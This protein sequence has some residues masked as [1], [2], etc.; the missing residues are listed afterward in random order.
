MIFLN[1]LEL[2]LCFALVFIK[3]LDACWSPY[4]F[5][6]Y[7]CSETRGYHTS[8]AVRKGFRKQ[9]MGRILSASTILTVEFN[10]TIL[11]C[12]MWSPLASESTMNSWWLTVEVVSALAEPVEPSAQW[13]WSW[14]KKLIQLQGGWTR[15]CVLKYRKSF[16]S[17]RTR[18]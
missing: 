14:R 5:N 1:V 16:W 4:S 2:D 18:Q 3:F 7:I 15:R 17:A 11:K 8:V 9:G 13:R 10:R 6:P 12:C